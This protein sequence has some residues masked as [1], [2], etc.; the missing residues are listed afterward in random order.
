MNSGKPMSSQVQIG[1]T[2]EAGWMWTKL[3]IIIMT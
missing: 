1:N 3:V 2:F